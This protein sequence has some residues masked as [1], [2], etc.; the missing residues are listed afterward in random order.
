[1]IGS[2]RIVD[3]RDG[4]LHSEYVS[5][6]QLQMGRNGARVKWSV[7]CHVH[8]VDHARLSKTNLACVYFRTFYE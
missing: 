8:F 7:L 3:E 6:V 5:L 1:M 2:N 4:V